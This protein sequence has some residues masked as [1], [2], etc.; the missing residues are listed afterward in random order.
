[1]SGITQTM[2]LEITPERAQ[3]IIQTVS[4]NHREQTA[5]TPV[6]V[7]LVSTYVAQSKEEH[8]GSAYVYPK[9]PPFA[10]HWGQ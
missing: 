1:M 4:A 7:L 8:A 9:Q 2:A 10:S 6:Y 3:E 5:S